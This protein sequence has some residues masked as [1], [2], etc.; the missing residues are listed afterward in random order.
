[1]TTKLT[2][3]IEGQVI[4]TAKKYA[5]IKGINLSRLIENY[6][7]KLSTEDNLVHEI[8]PRVARLRGSI[9]LPA[10]FDYKKMIEERI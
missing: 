10:D 6:L 9:K 7:R 8:T 2:L 4:K 5:Q 3:T 1:M